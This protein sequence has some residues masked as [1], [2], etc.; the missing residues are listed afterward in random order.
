MSNV[1]LQELDIMIQA[2]ESNLMVFKMIQKELNNKE[3]REILYPIMMELR[4]LCDVCIP[5]FK[6]T[7]KLS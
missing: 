4:T 6:P 7:E 5:A 3:K 1:E 2:L